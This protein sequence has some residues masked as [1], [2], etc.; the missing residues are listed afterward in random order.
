MGTWS[1]SDKPMITVLWTMHKT[2][3]GFIV[4]ALLSLK[5]FTNTGVAGTEV[6]QKAKIFFSCFIVR[7]LPAGLLLSVSNLVTCVLS[8]FS[9]TYWCV[10]STL[11][12]TSSKN[13]R[14]WCLQHGGWPWVPWLVSPEAP[15]WSWVQLWILGYPGGWGNGSLSL[16]FP[17][18]L[19]DGSLGQ[20]LTWAQVADTSVLKLR[21]PNFHDMPSFSPNSL[22]PSRSEYQ[23][24]FNREFVAT[25]RSSYHT[26]LRACGSYGCKL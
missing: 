22:V 6:Q 1:L 26:Y 11:N 5:S 3:K 7:F 12:A 19:V 2:V 14:L 25:E 9:P 24:R 15:S 8:T 20:P 10:K 18:V 21:L 4:T 23:P 16:T 17:V 13:K